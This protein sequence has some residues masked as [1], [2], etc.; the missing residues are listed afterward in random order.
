MINKT[1]CFSGHR[2]EKLPGKGDDNREETIFIKNLLND[3]IEKY[4]DDGYTCFLSGVARGIDLW[5]A[6][7]V[8][9]HRQQNPAIKLICV[10]PIKNQGENFPAEDKAEYERIISL[11]DSVVCTSDTYKKDCYTIRNKYMI[12]HSD[13]LIAFVKNYRSG[14]G[15]TINYARKQGKK[16]DITHLSNIESDMKYM[17]LSF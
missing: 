13:L 7:I 8:L 4:I 15:Q 1:V 16:A 2:P 3:K 10:K 9:K 5:A 14:T 17:Q 12:D 6:D 11:A